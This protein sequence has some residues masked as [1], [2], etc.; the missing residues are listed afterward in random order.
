MKIYIDFDGT[1]YNT[2]KLNNN[3]INIFN[4]YNIDKDYIKKL[5][6]NHKNYDNLANKII[7]DNNID[8]SIYKDIFNLYSSDLVFKDVIPF[9]EKYHKKYELILL[10]LGNKEYQEKK[11]NSSN[12]K[13]YFKNIIITNKDKSKLNI[14]YING[15]FIDNNP[16]ELKKFYNSKA[17]NLIRI[18]RNE[19]KYSKLN[20]DIENIPEFNNFEDLDNSNYLNKIGE[21]KHE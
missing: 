5:M 13:K 12:I 8:K 20:L 18:K 7:I 9:L 1:L 16:N 21:I 4:K 2:T 19:D 6:N 10:T 11:I 15:I 17:I 14:D 3:F